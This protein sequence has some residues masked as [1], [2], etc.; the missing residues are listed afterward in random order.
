MICVL[1]YAPCGISWQKAKPQNAK[2][3]GGQLEARITIKAFPRRVLGRVDGIAIEEFS[4]M[5][6]K[7]SR[8]ESAPSAGKRTTALSSN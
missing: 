1:W 4:A 5:I 2:S 8:W 6:G 7:S 3:E